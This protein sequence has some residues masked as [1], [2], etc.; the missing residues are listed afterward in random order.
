M[1]GGVQAKKKAPLLD[2][3]PLRGFGLLCAAWRDGREGLGLFPLAWSLAW[4]DI[5][6][7]YRGSLLGPFWLTISTFVMV[8]ALGFL[9]ARLLHMDIRHFLPFLS[10]SL[11][12]WNYLSTLANE[13]P[14]IFVQSAALMH[15][16]RMPLTVHVLRAILRNLL[17]F[18]HNIVVIAVVFV[19]FRVVPQNFV[20]T[21]PAMGLWVLDSAA[22]GLVLGLLGARFRDIGP[23]VSSLMQILFFVTPIIWQPELLGSARR[24]LL[25]DPFYPLIDI[26]RGPLLGTMPL[27]SIWL[28]AVAHSC[29]LWIVALFVFARFRARV[30]YWI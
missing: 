7:K 5:K 27:P 13:G 18:L 29:L 8:G 30:P 14:G 23:L 2:L 20:T 25:L 17:V 24:Y 26:L 12:L 9:Y 28:A 10:L 11:V 16:T 1:A 4:M 22:I 3:A 15:A 6:H 21:L 19:V